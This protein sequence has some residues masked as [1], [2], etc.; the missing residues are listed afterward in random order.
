MAA[1]RCIDLAVGQK[2]L[3]YDLLQGEEKRLVDAHLERCAACRD[4]LEQ[5]FGREGA[6]DEINWRAWRLM[7]RQRVEP[8]WWIPQRFHD[9]WLPFVLILSAVGLFSIFLMTRGEHDAVKIRRFAVTRAATI[10]STSTPHV[11][12]GANSLFLRTDRPARAYVYEVA[13]GAMRRLLPPLNGDAPE[14]G[15]EE[16]RELTLPELQ[17]R[18]ARI[19]LAL[20]PSG[21]PGTLDEWDEAM[22]QYLGRTQGRKGWPGG[23]HPTLRYYP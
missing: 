19:V 11:E 20:V 12:P 1:T 3:S 9:L 14:V 23:I 15:P 21:A 18:D 5:T 8:N 7:K 13:Q 22:F 6:L 10:D 4:F 2:I 16:V 17:A